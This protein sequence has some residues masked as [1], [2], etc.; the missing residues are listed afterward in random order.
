MAYSF[1]LTLAQFMDLLPIAEMTFDMPEAVEISETGAGEALAA[2]LGARLWTGEIRLDAMSNDEEA[3]VSAMLDVLRRAGAS[4]R[5][6]DARR[7]RPRDDLAGTKLGGAT[8][9]LTAVSAS[10][11]EIQI[12]GLP[13]AYRIQRG[14]MIGWTYGSDPTRFALHRAASDVTASA[15]GVASLI[16]VSPNVR[17]GWTAGAAVT[18]YRP[19]CKA[20]VIPGS[21]QPGRRRSTITTGMSF[22]FRQTLGR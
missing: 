11:R 2:D 5:C 3:V 22:R 15:G 7:P 16:E 10:T 9:T 8:P 13:A 12:S 19:V 14:D 20:I 6:Y 21:V 18:L 1:P 4:F 17:D